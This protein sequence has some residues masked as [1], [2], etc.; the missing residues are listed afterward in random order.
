MKILSLELEF[1]KFTYINGYVLKFKPTNYDWGVCD[2]NWVPVFF[3]DEN[4]ISTHPKDDF[5]YFFNSPIYFFKNKS[6]IFHKAKEIQNYLNRIVFGNDLELR[7]KIR[8]YFCC[9]ESVPLKYNDT[10]ASG[11][12][13]NAGYNR[14]WGKEKFK[15]LC[16]LKNYKDKYL[17]NN[18]FFRIYTIDFS[19]KILHFNNIELKILCI[20]FNSY[21]FARDWFNNYI[22]IH[23]VCGDDMKFDFEQFILQEINDIV[24]SNYE[25]LLLKLATFAYNINIDHLASTP[26]SDSELKK[27]YVSLNKNDYF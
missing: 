18:K 22:P 21:L 10:N 8:K 27:L 23:L 7:T 5:D 9:R 24:F 12:I 19:Y 20:P 6:Q 13:G 26:V 2:S 15:G 1:E 11:D 4:N 14:N 25:E 16:S 3:W 17:K